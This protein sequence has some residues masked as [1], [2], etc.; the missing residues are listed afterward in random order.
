V[1]E[2]KLWRKETAMKRRNS[3]IEKQQLWGRNKCGGKESGIAGR[4][5][6]IRKIL[7]CQQQAAV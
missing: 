4:N 5:N 6:S 2:G 3:C 7:L 1:G